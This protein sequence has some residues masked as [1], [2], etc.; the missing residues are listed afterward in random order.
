MVALNYKKDHVIINPYSR[1]GDKLLRVQAIV[2]HYTA[3]PGANAL[4]HAS[5]S[6]TEQTE[7]EDVMQVRTSS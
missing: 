4:M 3:N 2:I 6:S 1:S 7:A 5:T